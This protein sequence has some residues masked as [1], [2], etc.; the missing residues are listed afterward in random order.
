MHARRTRNED[1]YS[2]ARAART[3]SRNTIRGVACIDARKYFERRMSSEPAKRGGGKT[4]LFR[5]TKNEL[6]Y[7]DV[8][9]RECAAN[10]HFHGVGVRERYVRP[11]GKRN[12]LFVKARLLSR[13]ER[14]GGEVRKCWV[15]DVYFGKY[16][17]GTHVCAYMSARTRHTYTHTHTFNYEQS[18][19]R[20]QC[21]SRNARNGQLFGES[22]SN[23][24]PPDHSLQRVCV[25]VSFARAR[26]RLI[27]QNYPQLPLQTARTYRTLSQNRKWESVHCRRSDRGD[28]DDRA[29][30]ATKQHPIVNN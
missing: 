14:T 27:V 16:R 17:R 12:R 6:R 24:H 20:A 15:L 26:A 9:T 2:N 23:F 3:K 28:D 5:R 13:A 22:A 1:G 11:G 7:L 21:P 10:A 19:N 30:S 25:C 18:L 4:R 29:Q 8:L